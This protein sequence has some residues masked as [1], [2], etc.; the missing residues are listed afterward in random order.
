MSRCDV[1][2]LA[3]AIAAHGMPFAGRPYCAEI[4]TRNVIAKGVV[5]TDG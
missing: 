4:N 2:S 1:A 3:A 5:P